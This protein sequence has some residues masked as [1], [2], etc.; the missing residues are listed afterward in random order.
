MRLAELLADTVRPAEIP[1]TLRQSPVTGLDYDSRRIEP[2]WLFFAFPGARADGRAFA[3]AARERGAIATVSHEARPA[4]FDGPWIC[5]A[6]G[7]K[8]MALAARRLYAATTTLKLTGITGTNGKTTTTYLVDSI[9]RAAGH[10]TAVIGTI[11]FHLGAEMHPVANTTPESIDLYRM[12]DDVAGQGGTHVTMEVSSHALELG[13]VYGV[14]YEAAVFTNLT[15]DHLDF[16]GTMQNY[17]A[18]K[19]KLFGANGAPA[20]RH[21]VINFDDGWGRSIR[22]PSGSLAWWYGLTPGAT[23]RAEN[24]AQSFAGLAFDVSHPGGKMAIRSPMVGEFNVYNI[25]AACAT[26]LA[27]GIPSDIIAAGIAECRAVPGRFERV[28]AGQPFLVIVDYAH[29]H[30]ALRKAIEVARG[31]R[32]KRVITLFGCGGD[33]DRRKR[34]LMGEVAA[35]L[36]D[37]V[38]LTSDNP[39]SEDPLTIMSDAMVGL[40]RHDTPVHSEP[41]RELAIAHALSVAMPGDLVLLAGKGHENYQVLASKTIHFDDREVARSILAGGKRA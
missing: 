1:E 8:T 19:A 16:H 21:S 35:Q 11:G 17:F 39:R 37:Y 4:N 24:V 31:L 13:R 7:R 40:Q 27:F 14:D 36:S 28:E 26:G 20:P 32:P 12:F 38:V 22:V 6:H 41:D 33:R 2:G 18:A 25:L 15:Q 5:V 9:L 30:D 3:A 10:S 29:T 34:P 23:I